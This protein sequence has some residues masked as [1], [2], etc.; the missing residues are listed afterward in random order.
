MHKRIKLGM[1]GGGRGAFIGAVHRMAARL[2]DR[3]EL[4]AGAL[5]SDP[6]RAA[7]SADD[8]G[9][10]P[11][12]S[13]AD[14]GEMAAREGAMQRSGQ[15]GIEVVSI[16]TPNYLH[17]PIAKAF[18]RQG[19]HVICDK[20][21]AVSLDEALELRTLARQSGVLFVLTH[22]Y[23]GYPMI[24]HA[25]ALVAEGA[26]GEL[27]LLQ[28]E[29]SQDWWASAAALTGDGGWRGNP[30]IAGPV[31][32]L[33]DVGIHAYQL[34]SYVS[35]REPD[36][37]SAELHSFAPGRVLDDHVQVMMRYANG[38]RGTL[39]AS[40]VATGCENALTLRVYGSLA[41]LSFNQEEPN[42]LWLTPQGGA[43]QRLTRGRAQSDAA[44][45]A[46]RIPA[47]HPEGYIEAFAQLYRDAAD[48]I[49]ALDTGRAQAPGTGSL[50]G[51]CDGVSGHRFIEA[52][53]KSHRANSA[54]VRLEQ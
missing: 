51:V 45:G 5:S 19:I 28:A 42:V 48:Q 30:A 16:V 32:T 29:Y 3:Y 49:A 39:W 46:T 11:E 47:G 53:L 10:V 44:I 8:I 4:V 36:E 7:A 37:I 20:P 12:R 18:M 52:V 38:A 6:D 17:A 34:A 25:R 35:G 22:T 2:D 14:W 26:I 1:V 27:R 13:Y 33:G 43:A 31:G 54:W 23:T 15:G 9:I 41:Q 24:R 40:Q 50:P 21:L